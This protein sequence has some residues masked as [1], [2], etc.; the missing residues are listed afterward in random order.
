MRRNKQMQEEAKRRE[1]QAA[2]AA[3]E[4]E[5]QQ[6]DDERRRGQAARTDPLIF[7]YMQAML[8][9]SSLGNI[10]IGSAVSGDC[11]DVA[12]KGNRTNTEGVNEDKDGDDENGF[13]DAP[14]TDAVKL[15]V[16]AVKQSSS[17]LWANTFNVNIRE[18]DAEQFEHERLYHVPSISKHSLVECN[19]STRC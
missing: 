15:T 6:A 7:W 3:A 16:P 13:P 9:S 12:D 14:A 1:K 5:R 10:Q 18:H 11:S 2:E 19:T 17:R 8:G 4:A